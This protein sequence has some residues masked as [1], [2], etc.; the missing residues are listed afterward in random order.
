[1]NCVVQELAVTPKSKHK[2]QNGGIHRKQHKVHFFVPF[3]CGFSARRKDSLLLTLFRR[4]LYL[5]FYSQE[6][7]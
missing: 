5:H 4:K 3:L 2:T 6:W 1:M 7:A